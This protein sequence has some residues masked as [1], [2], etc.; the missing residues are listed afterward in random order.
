MAIPLQI[1]RV[2]ATTAALSTASGP[3]TAELVEYAC[4]VRLHEV[5]CVT[6]GIRELHGYPATGPFSIVSL[7]IPTGNDADS[8][9]SL[10]LTPRAG[11]RFYQSDLE[12]RARLSRDLVEIDPRMPP[13]GT[14]SFRQQ[15]GSRTLVF[16]FTART[17]L[18]RKLTVREDRDSTAMVS[19]SAG[20]GRVDIL[21]SFMPSFDEPLN[22]G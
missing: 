1:D 11:M 17:R 7:R 5:D 16:E 2:H 15:R 12:Q 13:E 21:P 6:P 8:A 22:S 10:T 14:V 9:T 4:V 19:P 3:L 20:N 18:L